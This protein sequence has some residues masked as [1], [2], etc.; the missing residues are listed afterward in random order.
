MYFSKHL[1]LF[2]SFADINSEEE[3]SLL[4]VSNTF[5]VTE[6]S[7]FTEQVVVTPYTF[8]DSANQI[9]DVVNRGVHSSPGAQ[10]GYT[11]AFNTYICLPS[12]EPVNNTALWNALLTGRQSEKFAY[13][14]GKIVNR[15]NYSQ[16]HKVTII[17]VNGDAVQVYTNC[18]AESLMLDLNISALCSGAWTF[19][20][21]M[22]FKTGLLSVNDGRL[23]YSGNPVSAVTDTNLEYIANKLILTNISSEA[24]PINVNVAATMAQLA[25]TN[26][27]ERVPVTVIDAVG[28]ATS[29]KFGSFSISGAVSA[30]YRQSTESLLNHLK[31]E[32]SSNSLA[33]NKNIEFVLKGATRSLRLK[34]GACFIPPAAVDTSSIYTIN[35]PFSVNNY[36]HNDLTL[37]RI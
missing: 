16:L 20:T 9:S 24:E 26:A 30:Y 17:A 34:L 8:G 35:F 19:Q 15:S 36:Y 13:S 25:F 12:V 3:L 7:S 31:S 2:V 37:E 27:V 22:S 21:G 32:Y 33:N 29:Y 23:V 11:V 4:D 14:D 5:R 1:K 18:A 10:T 28:E 6:L